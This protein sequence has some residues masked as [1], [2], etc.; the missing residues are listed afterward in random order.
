MRLI[1][2]T[3]LQNY[4]ILLAAMIVIVVSYMLFHYS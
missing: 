1:R 4:M 3:A 2:A